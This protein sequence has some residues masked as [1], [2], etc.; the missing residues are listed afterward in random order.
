MCDFPVIIWFGFYN[1]CDNKI[2]SRSVPF[3]FQWR[4]LPC[5]PWGKRFLVYVWVRLL[6]MGSR[7]HMQERTY[8]TRYLCCPWGERKILRVWVRLLPMGP[9]DHMQ[10]RS[11]LMCSPY[12]AWGERK[13]LK[14]TGEATTHGA[15]ILHTIKDNIMPVVNWWIPWLVKCGIF[16]INYLML[17]SMALELYC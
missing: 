10:K 16:V 8:L 11:Y 3:N 1:L 14:G 17:D 7:D 4:V 13:N 12:C 2:K 6:P 15:K 5:C 9:K